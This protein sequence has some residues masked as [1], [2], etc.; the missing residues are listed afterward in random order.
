MAQPGEDGG[1]GDAGSDAGDSLDTGT[2]CGPVP[3]PNAWPS[4]V[5][6]NPVR[7]G[8]PNPASYTVSA[9]GNQV[10]DN[11]T[12]LAWQRRIDSR[13]YT[14]DDARG[15]CTC[16]SLDES[17]PGR[18]RL[19]SRIELASI[20]DWTTAAPAID[21]TAFPDTPSDDFWSSSRFTSEA[22]LRLLVFF[23]NGYTSFGNYADTYHIR[24]V[25][26]AV[27]APESMGSIDPPARYVVADGTVRDS[28]TRLTWQQAISTERY[29][30]PDAG[31]YCAQLPLSGAG[32]R[33]PSI[34]EL[35]TIVDERTFPAID[36]ATFPDTPSE[37][38][39]SS[40][41]DAEAPSQVW[42]VFFANG[43]TYRIPVTTLKNVRCVR[44]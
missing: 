39:W 41:P 25:R 11:V 24:C 5:M 35:Q 37:Y 8:L 31:S 26:T 34:G 36:A 12:G 10:S 38:F 44:P 23:Q 1:G 9:S 32:W 13:L 16:L 17:G 21:S 27:P 15:A 3:A 19:P 6:P 43:T 30:W 40:S 2:A 28:Q 7:S 18:W 29:A 22:D 14:W 20:A 42:T 4:W 33:V